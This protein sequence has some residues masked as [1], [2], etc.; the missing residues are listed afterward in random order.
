MK[1]PLQITLF[2]L[3]VVIL[4]IVVFASVSKTPNDSDDQ[5][6]NS[7]IS[8][9]SENLS[10]TKNNIQTP[11]PSSQDQLLYLIEEEKLAHDVYSVL[12]QK[13]GSQVFGNIIDSE[14]SHQSQ[15]LAA[16]SARNISDPR[17]PEVGKFKDPELQKFYDS[18]IE[19]GNKSLEDAYRVG[20]KIEEKDINDLSAQLGST[21]DAELTKLLETLRSGSENH[22]RAFNRQLSRIS[23]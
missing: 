17:L 3:L 8:Q 11:L 19:E 18:L 7:V 1:K 4:S 9:Q 22:L 20:V 5:Q 15:V 23:N 12:Y 14:T 13:Y 21:T 2:A 10:N 6:N 16:L